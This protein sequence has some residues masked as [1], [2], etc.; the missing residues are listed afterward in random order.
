MAYRT[1][2]VH[3]NDCRHVQ[4]C[5]D[6][7]ARIA[8]AENAHLIGA[9]CTGIRTPT[10][11]VDPALPAFTYDI[12]IV[13]ERISRALSVYDA[14]V[15]QTGV[16]SFETRLID[17]EPGEM[18]SMLARHCDLAVLGQT[19]ADDPAPLVPADF[20]DHVSMHCGRPVLIVPRTGQFDTVG[21]RPLVAW[22]GSPAAARAVADAIA[23]L[24]RAGQAEL[25]IFDPEKHAATRTGQ[26]QTDIALYL[27]RHDIKVKVTLR[28]A[29]GPVG[30][31]I[32]KLAGELGSDMIVMGAYGHR[33]LRELLLG[34]VTRTIL[35]SMTVPV[36]VSH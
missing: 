12:D 5:I 15:R 22:D 27:A 25:V 8:R 14:G 30:P 31:A 11:I 7:A 23:L 32:L 34:G 28:P 4:Q 17:G 9:A 2:L 26:A 36:L 1:I 24:R 10:G 21:E 29:D 33:R 20:P 16:A 35:G 3:V 13:H 18:I 19:D 6:V